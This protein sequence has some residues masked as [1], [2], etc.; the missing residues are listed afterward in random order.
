MDINGGTSFGSATTARRTKARAFYLGL[1]ASGIAIAASAG[2]PN[3]KFITFD[4]PGEANASNPLFGSLPTGVLPEGA[5]CFFLSDCSVIINE[6]GAVTAYYVDANFAFH[7]F[8]RSPDGNITVFD[9][10]EGVG[11]TFPNAISDAAAVTGKYSDTD[12]VTHGFLRSP[13]GKFY[14]TIDPPGSTGTSGIA[15]N[16][17]GAVVGYYLPQNEA[18]QSFLRDPDG[19]FETWSGPGQCTPSSTTPC[20]GGGAFGI[21]VFGTV[22]AAYEDTSGAFHGLVRRPEGQLTPYNAPGAG[23]GPSQGTSCPGCS[24]P[25][26]QWG[27]IAGYYTDAS[28]VQHGYLRSPEGSITTFDFPGSTAPGCP[29]DCSMG[30]NNFGAITGYY[31]DANYR[32]RGFLRSPAGKLI[33]LDAPGAGTEPINPGGI[34]GAGCLFGFFCQG[35]FPVSIN[36]AGVIAGYY[37]DANFI[38]HGFLL[39]APEGG[40]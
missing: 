24:T 37:V 6:S 14:T 4:V 5:G 15:L 29:S 26:N 25:I 7:G 2:T 39:L 21:T 40:W 27:S 8:V 13:N 36:D 9:E 11:S 38:S 22:A 31:L 12:G 3:M 28:G 30:L 35:T 34:I 23:T 10:P 1:C 33:T 19:S 32:L 17:E 18:S 16:L 20:Y